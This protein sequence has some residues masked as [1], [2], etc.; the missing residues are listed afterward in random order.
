MRITIENFGP[1]EKFDFDTDKSL[2]L[3][4]GNNNVG[5]SYAL[6]AYYFA[7]KTLMYFRGPRSRYFFLDDEIEDGPEDNPS[8]I[9]K[10]KEKKAADL[11]I[12]DIYHD[13]IMRLLKEQVA[14]EFTQQIKSSFQ[15]FDSIANQFS[16]AEVSRITFDLPSL[17]FVLEG[18]IDEFKVTDVEFG[19][20]ILL[21]TVKQNRGASLSG[22]KLVIY[23]KVTDDARSVLE[24]IGYIAMRRVSAL[25]LQATRKISDINYLPAS[26]SGLYQALSA[27][28]LII[29][30]LSKNRSFVSSKIELPGISGQ[31]SDYFIR[32]T[33]I[34]E[35]SVNAESAFEEIAS[36]IES[37][38]LKGKIEYDYVKK[39]LY[40]RPDNTTLR[41]DLSAT[42]S[43]VSEIG[44]VVTYIRH[45]LSESARRPRR[46]SS[47][48]QNEEPE[49]RKQILIIEEPEAH[50]HPLNQIKMTQLYADLTKIGVNVIMTSHSNYVFNKVSNLVMASQLE[51]SEVRCDLFEL[52]DTGS[53]G[54]SQEIDQYGIDD[55]NFVDASE[56]LLNEKFL[57]LEREESD[58]LP[59]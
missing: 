32:L 6:A 27:F 55:S 50:L 52:K 26:R 35:S 10:L 59:N 30:E 7:I 49:V 29:A 41:L 9:A 33:S 8:F 36:T 31:L 22:G 54:L 42:S 11:D 39:K 18:N 38:V 34:A 3:I 1:V 46:R 28:G 56:L 58:D 25:I 40:Y 53:I 12:G 51:I 2:H 48:S 21:R 24:S 20:K 43:M 57:M 19:Y 15:E 17:K 16:G 5:K 44:P 4:V 45:I 23:R 37:S 13:S 14:D 47:L